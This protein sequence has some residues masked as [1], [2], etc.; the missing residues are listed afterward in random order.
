MN[1]TMCNFSVVT[2]YTIIKNCDRSAVLAELLNLVNPIFLVL[3]D[4]TVL[5]ITM[6]KLEK[7]YVMLS[8][9]LVANHCWL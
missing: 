1:P 5:Q 2:V 9:I 8:R 3:Q 7:P 6:I 4:K